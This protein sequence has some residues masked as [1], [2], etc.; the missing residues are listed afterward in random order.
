MEA[1]MA[2]VIGH[3]ATHEHVGDLPHGQVAGYTTGSSDIRW[4]D[5]D[6]KARPGAV[7]ICQDFGSD[8]TADVLDVERGAATNTEAAVW[9]LRA[10]ASFKATTRAGQRLP[11]IYTSASNVTP[12]VNELVAAKLRA[13]GLWVANWNLSDPQAVADVQNAAGPYPIHAVQFSSGARY[14]TDVFSTAW[15][16]DVSTSGPGKHLT[17]AGDTIDSLSASRNMS[18]EGFLTLQRRLG[19][20]VGALADGPLAAGLE[21]RTVK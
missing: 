1:F 20:N 6:W 10:Y 11:L 21:W 15:L 3:D 12:L 7:R 13:V 2:V 8:H 16:S 9:V 17:K 18:P 5:A 19:T 4:T 14:D